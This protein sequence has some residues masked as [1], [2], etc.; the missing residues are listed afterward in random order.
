MDTGRLINPLALESTKGDKGTHMSTSLWPRSADGAILY[1]PNICPAGFAREI[2]HT[3]VVR[4]AVG[5]VTSL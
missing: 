1:T 2:P 5:T 4:Q 3:V